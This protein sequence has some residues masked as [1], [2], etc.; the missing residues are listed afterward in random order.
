MNEQ[1]TALLEQGEAKGCVNLSELNELVQELEPAD[2]ELEDFYERAQERE[3]EIRDDCG[4]AGKDDS[5][6]VNGELT[7]A[8][9]DALQ[10]FLNEAGRYPLLTAAEE[11]E[12]A[13][14]IERGDKEAKDLMV[15][16][17]LRL[18]VS[19]AKKY[20]GHGLSL[21]DLIQEGIIGLIR[22][23][24]K[25]DWRKGFK[26]STYATW[27]IRQAV[28]RGVANKSRTI[29][30]PVHIVEREQ[31]IARAERKLLTELERPP[32]DEELSKET[33]LPVK[34]VREV[35][36]AAR[37]VTS[38]D[39]P[40]GKE[41]D[42][43]LGDIVAVESGSPEQEVHVSLEHDA[44][45]RAVS[46]L[47]TREREVVKMRFGLNG[48]PDPQSLEQ[49]GRHLGLTRE[50]VRQIEREALNLLAMNREIDAVAGRP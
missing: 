22:A 24:E 12:L 44:V 17:N 18:V 29:R 30:I 49:I 13:K 8:T 35:R 4:H 19:I 42:S 3:L 6:Y 45:R 23:A 10:L 41:S 50:R 43:S 27:W 20:Q 25:F 7:V 33:K 5:T 1:L 34:Q 37:A 16:S 38:L 15:N 26:F 48:D 2:T 40:L 32:T 11:V 28:Q 47:P 21:L 31:K 36:H 9:T 46:Q 14:R 39:K